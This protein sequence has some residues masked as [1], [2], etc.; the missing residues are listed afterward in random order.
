MFSSEIANGAAGPAP[1]PPTRCDWRRS[2][3]TQPLVRAASQPQ[4]ASL[5]PSPPSGASASPAPAPAALGSS[6][7]GRF[8]NCSRGSGPYARADGLSAK[9]Q[10]RNWRPEDIQ[11]IDNDGESGGGWKHDVRALRN[12]RIK[13]PRPSILRFTYM[14]TS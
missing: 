10:A 11:Q 4:H 7:P 3:R 8:L 1:P 5:L 14:I 13:K 9:L 12:R 6:G 2:P